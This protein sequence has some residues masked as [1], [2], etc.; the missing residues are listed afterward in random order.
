VY[1][2]KND[3]LEFILQKNTENLCF[4]N[5]IKNMKLKEALQKFLNWL[6]II[7]NK[8]PKTIEQYS[9]HLRYFQDY[10]N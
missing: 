5:L 8:S 7:K 4:L 9:R 6:E 10:L 3:D 2:L 1:L